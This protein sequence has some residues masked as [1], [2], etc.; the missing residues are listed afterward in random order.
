MFDLF[1]QDDPKT[2]DAT[3]LP[4][5]SPASLVRPPA[6]GKGSRMNA[7]SGPKLHGLLAYF[8][9]P[10]CCWRTF[11]GSSLFAAETDLGRY[12]ETWPTSG[13]MRNGIAFRRP[14]L[15]PRTCVTD[16]L[17]LPT[18]RSREDGCYQRDRGQ[19]GQE[20]ATLMG[21]LKGWM[22]TLAVSGGSGGG[23][24]HPRWALWYMGF[25]E[26]WCDL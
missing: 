6:S 10:G 13:M 15:A 2:G 12:S 19:K 20:R 11:P 3:S 22:P 14:P 25:P 23:R 9:R 8:D 18:L 26:D 5:G 7:G 21:V 24:I 1:H 17:L 4:P 16:Y